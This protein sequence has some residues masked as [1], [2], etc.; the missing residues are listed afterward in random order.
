[1]REAMTHILFLTQVLPYPLDAGPKI[2]A[3]YVLRHL[4]QR[5]AVTLVS[6]V[7]DEDRLEHVNHLASICQ[8]VHTVPMRRSRVRDLHAVAKATLHRLPVIIARDEIEDMRA[9]LR[10]MMAD[11]QFDV[12]HADQTSMVQYAQF[13]LSC[14]KGTSRPNM[15]L[16]AHNALFRV[17]EQLAE[18][19][20]QPLKQML[21]R[22]E[23]RALERYEERVYASFD[24][25]VFV[26]DQ[27]RVRLGH[28]FLAE[29]CTTIPICID[30]R[31]NSLVMPNPEQRTVTHLGTMF[32]PPN[33]DG[34]RW[35]AQQVWPL[36]LQKASDARL[37]VIGKRPPESVQML[38]AN[39]PSIEVLGYVPDPEPYLQ[40]TAAFIVPLRAGAGMRVKIID[41]WCWGLPIV[42]TTL[43]AEGIAVRDGEDILIADEPAA[44]AEAVVR[45]LT[46][47][48]LRT[49]LRENGRAGVTEC[50]DW[51]HVYQQWDNVYDALPKR[52][53]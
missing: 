31:E 10:R 6:F 11:Q 47:P 32:W 42:S 2:R 27:D 49:R 23:A 25:V 40:E 12:I 50:Y 34:V 51:R 26:N 41:A 24:H 36:V 37:V 53:R 44:F 48:A 13:A 20:R 4:A 1:M 21:L 28:E 17:F 14:A 22:R 19:E 30:P 15:V 45:L 29:H 8:A 35:F 16:D 7:R 39:C 46:D 52:Q 18:E 38:S 33:V 5:H 43:G 9:L 3:Y